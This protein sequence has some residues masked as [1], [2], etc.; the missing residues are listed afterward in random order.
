MK[1]K[2]IVITDEAGLHA[3]P[4]SKI[5]K[6]ASEY[7]GDIKLIFEGK[8]IDLKSILAVMSL[9]VPQN[10]EVT[11]T[12]DGGDEDKTMQGLLDAFGEQGI[13]IKED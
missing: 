1:K 3:R 7:P 5:S 13:D 4:A 8:E 11:L 10:G 12:V 2:T 9:A 6:K